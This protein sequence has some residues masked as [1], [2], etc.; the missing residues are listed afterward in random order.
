M[1]KMFLLRWRKKSIDTP[2]T[3]IMS[4]K[5]AFTPLLLAAALGAAVLPT[6][7]AAEASPLKQIATWTRH[8]ESCE[9]AV[10]LTYLRSNDVRVRSAALDL[11]ESVTG[12]D[13]G[14]DPW[15][16]PAA[17]PAEVQQALQQWAEVESKL[18]APATAP[19]AAKLR[20]AVAVLRTADAD[21]MR[22][23]CLRFA[24]YPA[25]L[26]YAIEQEL[27]NVPD[28]PQPEVDKLR[29]AQ[30]R[31]QLQASMPADA[32]RIAS[33]L[34]SHVRSDT[35]DALE[36]LREVDAAALP[37]LMT[38]VRHRDAMVREVAVD[39]LL[40]IGGNA[41][42]EVL[43]PDLMAET[44]RNILQIAA[45]RAIDC[46][47]TVPLIGF[48]NKCAQS[49]DEDISIAG[50]EAMAE[51][52]A[53]SDRSRSYGNSKPASTKEALTTEAVT[54]LLQSPHWR[55][56]AA[57]LSFLS[58]PA[59]FVPSLSNEQ[60][61]QVVVGCLKDQDETVRQTAITVIYKRAL[62]RK[63]MEALA[64]FAQ[65]SPA[66]APYIIYLFCENQLELPAG[67]QELLTR[68][69]VNE[70]QQLAYYD[71]EYETL[72]AE[73]SPSKRA[74]KILEALLRNPDPAVQAAVM[75]WCGRYIAAHS[76]ELAN[77]FCD[78]LAAP[79]TTTEDKKRFFTSGSIVSFSEGKGR[80]VLKSR[81]PK[82][83]EAELATP[84]A[85]DIEYKAGLV[86]ALFHL[87]P[88]AV[89]PYL[90]DKELFKNNAVKEL[91]YESSSL[92]DTLDAELLATLL[93]D[94]EL[95]RY[96]SFLDKV[97]SS[98]KSAELLQLIKLTDKIF[99][100][101]V[102]SALSNIRYDS[103]SR[104]KASISSLLRRVLQGEVTEQCRYWAV[105]VVLC[106][107][108]HLEA[109]L[110]EAVQAAIPSL[111][112]AQQ[113]FCA[114]LQTYP[115]TA[116][117]V[118]PWVQQY[119]QSPNPQIRAA[120]AACLLPLDAWRPALMFDEEDDSD[121]IFLSLPMTRDDS[122]KRV[123]CPASLIQL[124]AG[125]QDDEDAEVAMVACASMLYRTGDCDRKRFMEI[126]EALETQFDEMESYTAKA[127][128]QRELL[129]AVW[130][131]W[132]SYRNDV[133][134]PFK[135]KGSPKKLKAG[136]DKVL[137]QLVHVSSSAY[138]LL[139]NVKAIVDN[140]EEGTR[141]GKSAA[142]AVEHFAFTAPPVDQP[143]PPAKTEP[144]ED[145]PVADDADNTESDTITQLDRTAPVKVEFFHK[146]GCDICKRAL[147][148]LD[149]LRTTYPNLRV[150]TY[151]VESEEGRERNSVLCERFAVAPKHRRKAPALFAEAGCLLGERVDSDALPDLLDASLSN[152]TFEDKLSETPTDEPVETPAE[153]AESTATAPEAKPSLLAE[154]TQSELTQV[155]E[156]SMWETLKSYA[157]L[158]VGA[159]AVLI[160]LL[161]L[162]FG[163]KSGRKEQS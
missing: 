82:W 6:V 121:T 59:A 27:E 74:V 70:V 37:V 25:A 130:K 19:D 103:D 24:A 39:V 52:A 95:Y 124:V 118:E 38:F 32:G 55:V 161:F 79:T 48:L 111:P 92:L 14:L 29:C 127:R 83:L 117:A 45:R 51:M 154:T 31:V 122:L 135:L 4:R 62:A 81:L 145:T 67:L 76:K 53:D 42:F 159:L 30:F 102:D 148:R 17:V 123:S 136:V 34:T 57:T 110:K 58:K 106:E 85:Q 137:R 7:S 73:S 100:R 66:M 2:F 68:F 3:E 46:A 155:Q 134:E 89:R 28:L 133:S 78:W 36:A 40:Q 101:I 119:A 120:V 146:S 26:A 60:L 71:D 115:A 20:E 157:V 8:P 43:M 112:Q 11:L 141:S 113:E 140:E 163:R 151:D 13:F 91:V 10:L 94:E 125:M 16:A 84:A 109:D 107:G 156:E 65:S 21:T 44:D 49:E 114:F 72:F 143:E 129:S 50:L 63:N 23:V 56:R 99:I 88:D 150:K 77:T 75:H 96:G 54:K 149:T 35:L 15:L 80:S 158:I 41:A 126:M 132:S 18:G 128:Y 162:L 139:D 64:E 33:G 138:G 93:N 90:T 142:V 97:L 98:E 116:D 5:F 153:P 144:E 104:Y 87:T 69:T 152:T 160:G 1:A 131:R 105:L 22:R 108:Q 12:K 86:C 61:Q 147:A 47:P 9:R